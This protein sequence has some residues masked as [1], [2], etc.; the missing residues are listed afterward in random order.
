MTSDAESL[1]Q[2]ANLSAPELYK[3]PVECL[4]LPG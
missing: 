1:T 3:L 2:C 4:A